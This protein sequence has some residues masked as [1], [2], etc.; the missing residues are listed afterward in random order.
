MLKFYASN[1][2]ENDRRRSGLPSAPLNRSPDT[3]TIAHRIEIA[4]A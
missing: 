4:M 3:I 2:V 1:I